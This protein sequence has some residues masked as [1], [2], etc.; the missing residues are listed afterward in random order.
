MNS[1]SGN[2]SVKIKPS[3][4]LASPSAFLLAITKLAR[5]FTSKPG[6]ARSDTQAAFQ[7]HKHIVYH[8]SNSSNRQKIDPELLGKRLHNYSDIGI[9]TSIGYWYWQGND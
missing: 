4:P 2:Y 6:I 9:G 3:R 1:F 8:M 7:E 5:P